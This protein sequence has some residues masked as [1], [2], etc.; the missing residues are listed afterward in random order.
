MIFRKNFSILLFFVLLSIS[1]KL[2]DFQPGFGGP[3]G[4]HGR[5]GGHGPHRLHGPHGSPHGFGIRRPPPFMH[6]PVGIRRPGHLMS[7][8]FMGPRGP[9]LHGGFH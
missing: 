8:H 1:W 7:P 9:H 6:H 2:C 5:F 3:F 4:R